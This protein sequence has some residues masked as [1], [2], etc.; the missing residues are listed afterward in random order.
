M[1]PRIAVLIP[2]YNEVVAI[3]KVVADFR[4]VLPEATI[5]VYD[6]NSSDGTAAAARAAGA[7][8]RTETLQGKG[9]VIRR[10]FGDIEAD[11]YVMVDGDD[12]YSAAS[13]PAMVAML[14]DDGLDMINGVR[15]TEIAAAYRRGHKF[16]NAMLTRPRRFR[17][18]RPGVRHAVGLPRVLPAGS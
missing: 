9:H 13:A 7:V 8:V 3:P 5:Y 1:S 15:V 12:T 10:M 18:R 2:C 11:A 6:N 14:L 4:A 16:G 17:V